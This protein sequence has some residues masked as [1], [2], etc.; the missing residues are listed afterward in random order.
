MTGESIDAFGF[1]R[2]IPKKNQVRNNAKA[3]FSVTG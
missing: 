3:P 2:L 1:K